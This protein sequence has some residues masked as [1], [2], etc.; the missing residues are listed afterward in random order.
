M[1]LTRYWANDFQLF[2]RPTTG[3]DID[4]AWIH[5]NEPANVSTLPS[6]FI[7]LPLTWPQQQF[8]NLPCDD[9]FQQAIQQ[10]HPPPRTS[11]LPAHDP[12][13]FGNQTITAQN[14]RRDEDISNPPYAIN[15]TAGPLA[16]KTSWVR[17][18]SSSLCI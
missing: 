5:M 8:C 16:S 14:E 2:Y 9:P 17:L 13:I 18:F 3:L 12:P 4:G 10:N 1:S 7:A 11:P 6:F 15:N